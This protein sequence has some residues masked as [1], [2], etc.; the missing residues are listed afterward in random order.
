MRR[1]QTADEPLLPPEATKY[2]GILP[3]PV[4]REVV[5][6]CCQHE[7]AEHLDDVMIRRTSWHYYHR[8]ADKI[9]VDVAGWMAEELGWDTARRD[10]EIERYRRV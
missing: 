5:T 7:W 3:P 2:S 6:D 1:C 9:A 4:A 10:A 8:D